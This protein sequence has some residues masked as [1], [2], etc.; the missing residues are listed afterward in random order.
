M[1]G[2]GVRPEIQLTMRTVAD[3]GLNTCLV[4]SVG[5]MV[6]VQPNEDPGLSFPLPQPVCPF[7]VSLPC[8]MLIQLGGRWRTFFPMF[9]SDLGVE[10]S[11]TWIAKMVRGGKVNGVGCP[12]GAFMIEMIS[13]FPPF[14]RVLL[15]LLIAF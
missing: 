12:L 13:S 10:L 3:M 11:G 7:V 8:D 14:C 6:S 5:R 15:L 1:G 9:G 2:R 4:L